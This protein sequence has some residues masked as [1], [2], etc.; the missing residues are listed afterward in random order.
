[1]GIVKMDPHE[2]RACAV[3]GEVGFGMLHHVH[4]TALHPSPALFG[5]RMFREVVVKIEAVIETRRQ[6]LA[7]ENYGSDESGGVIALLLQSL[8][9]RG[10]G[11]GE[12]NSEVGY[13]MNAGKK[14]GED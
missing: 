10:V 14:P 3:R 5:L 12:R 4:A 2:M 6:G 13:A 11:G 8:S 7:V 9:E 1:M